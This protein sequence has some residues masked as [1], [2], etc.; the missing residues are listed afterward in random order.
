[1]KQNLGKLCGKS[2]SEWDNNIPDPQTIGDQID[3]I[4][5]GYDDI[6]EELIRAVCSVMGISRPR[7]PWWD[8]EDSNIIHLSAIDVDK[9]E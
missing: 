2:D 7:V 1:M 6:Y 4:M 5:N 8:G 3:R 9:T